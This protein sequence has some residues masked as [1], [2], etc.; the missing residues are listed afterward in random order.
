MIFQKLFSID[1]VLLILKRTKEEW[2]II[3]SFFFNFQMFTFV[4]VP[5]ST[6]QIIAGINRREMWEIH[7]RTKAK[8]LVKMLVEP[9][10]RL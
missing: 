3:F 9:G 10:G 6:F 5:R 4:Q 1:A 7:P 8:D 2:K